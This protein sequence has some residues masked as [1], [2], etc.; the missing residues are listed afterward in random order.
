MRVRNKLVYIL[1]LLS[2]VLRAQEKS[3]DT[4][5]S[6]LVRAI[7]DEA[8]LNGKS[9][10]QLNYLCKAIGHRITGSQQAELALEWA[11]S[12]VSRYNVDRLMMQN[13][14]AEH[15]VRGDKE[16]VAISEDVDLLLNACALGGSVSTDGP[17]QA[18][19]VEVAAWK[20]CLATV[21][22]NSKVK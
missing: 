13:V 11:Q 8:L 9:Y 5:D 17:L 2:L 7:F 14:Q 1:C 19:V 3:Y 12:E 6:L 22:E 4:S 18:Q 15:W 21:Q 10:E 16:W 20:S